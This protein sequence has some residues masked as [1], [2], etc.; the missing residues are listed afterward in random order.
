M[1]IMQHSSA[2]SI[3]LSAYRRAREEVSLMADGR[4]YIGWKVMNVSSALYERGNRLAGNPCYGNT[5]E[6]WSAGA[7]YGHQLAQAE[8]LRPSRRRITEALE[9]LGFEATEERL[10]A[11]GF[12]PQ[13]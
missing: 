7:Q 8:T 10:A 5:A 11:F 13:S 1:D 12:N 9:G 2:T 4:A 6:A 3:V